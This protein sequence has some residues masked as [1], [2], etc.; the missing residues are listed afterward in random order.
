[1]LPVPEAFDPVLTYSALLMLALGFYRS[2]YGVM[3]FFIIME[4]K[5]GE[6][7][8][9]LGAMRIELVASIIVL[10]QAL[11]TR[12]GMMRVVDFTN[13]SHKYIVAFFVIAM[14][15]VLQS[16]NINVSWNN[17]D[18]G[19]YFLLRLMIFYVMLV[20]ALETREDI[21]KMVWAFLAMALWA[22][23]E[24]FYTHLYGLGVDHG[25]GSVATGR[26]KGHVGSANTLT[27]ALPIVYFFFLAKKSKV[28]KAVILCS[29]IIMVSAVVFT[30]SRGGFLGLVAVGAGTTYLSENRK[31]AL[32]I[33]GGVLA[34][35]LAFAGTSYLDRIATIADGVH[36]SRSSSDRYMGLV[37]GIAM[38]ARRPLMG[39]GIGCYAYA[40]GLFFNYRFYAHNLYGEVIGELGMMSA[41]WFLWIASIIRG[42]A[43]V[44]HIRTG[45][46][47][48]DRYFILLSRAVMLGIAVRLF[49]GLSS[50]CAYIWYWFLLSALGVALTRIAAEAQSR[51]Y[52]LGESGEIADDESSSATT[53]QA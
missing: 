21:D 44:G 1:M 49:L 15:S 31:R 35:I 46:L 42:A 34:A 37:H 40:R 39:V 14:V 3:G 19:G 16:V 8:P 18:S 4:G 51:A 24:P 2:I 38:A 10:A 22:A 17:L 28:K 50:H 36:A 32:L 48:Q 5:L 27:Q 6:V 33:S 7:D 20:G 25:Y 11:L 13:R 47:E 29:G 53:V 9:R 26:F 45:D 12:G 52:M 23:Y 30:K 43:R 41:F